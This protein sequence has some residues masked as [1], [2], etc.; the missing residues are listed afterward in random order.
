MV[1]YISYTKESKGLLLRKRRVAGLMLLEAQLG[2]ENRL[3]ERLYA[4]RAAREM[5]RRGI[6]EAV[7]PVDY[8]HGDLFARR[9]ILPVDLLP[10]HRAMAPLVVKS[11]MNRMGLSAG[12]TTAAVAAERMTAEVGK[13]V[14][15]LALSTRYVML[16]APGAEEFCYGLQREYGV[17]VILSP[18]R[19]QLEEA[20]ALLLLKPPEEGMRLKQPILLHLYDG[21]RVLRRNGVDFALPRRLSEQVEENCCQNQLVRLLL[22]EGMLQNYQIPII[23]VDITGKSYYNASTVNNIE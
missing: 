18:R 11:R 4:R 5:A 22:G 7:F 13:I 20:D 9:G 3:L 8:P 14:R 10:L 12:T 6:R 17:S 21:E 1:G 19:R 23:E 15:E 2:K 16:D